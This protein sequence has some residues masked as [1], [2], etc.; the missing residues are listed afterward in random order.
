MAHNPFVAEP[1]QAR[2]RYRTPAAVDRE[3]ADT[4]AAAG[5]RTGSSASIAPATS[6]VRKCIDPAILM[7]LWL[8]AT[9]DGVG[10]ARELDRL[11]DSDFAP[12]QA[13]NQ[14][15]LAPT[16][17]L[18]VE[19]SRRVHSQGPCASLRRINLRN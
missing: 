17:Q 18:P 5:Q 1:D 12:Y 6:V 14:R 16:D 4:A 7:S 19:S 3:T 8:Y 15:K 2:V 9:L 10:S 11:C 13:R